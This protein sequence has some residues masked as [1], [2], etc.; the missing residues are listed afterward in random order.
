MVRNS[1]Q[2]CLFWLPLN[3]AVLCTVHGL[4]ID[5]LMRLINVNSSILM[6]PWSSLRILNDI[7]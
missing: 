5:A 4:Q 7:V 3:I 1:L 2:D 6:W